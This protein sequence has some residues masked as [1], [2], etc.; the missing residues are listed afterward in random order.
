MVT[1]KSRWICSW[2]KSHN[3]NSQQMAVILLV[4]MKVVLPNIFRMFQSNKVNVN[5]VPSV[6]VNNNGDCQMSRNIEVSDVYVHEVRP[7]MT[8]GGSGGSVVGGAAGASNKW[9]VR[10]K[11]ARV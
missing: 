11:I 7:V 10:G 2:L 6:T 3:K 8:V 1:N 4:T 9:I 5:G